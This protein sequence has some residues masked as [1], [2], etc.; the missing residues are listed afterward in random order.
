MQVAGEYLFE[1]YYRKVYKICRKWRYDTRTT[2]SDLT[3][4][5]MEKML[6]L[7]KYSWDPRKETMRDF[8]ARRWY[9]TIGNAWRAE[10]G[11][12]DNHRDPPKRYGVALS[13]DDAL[14]DQGDF[15]VAKPVYSDFEEYEEFE[16]IVSKLPDGLSRLLRD[17][18]YLNLSGKEIA[19]KY[20]L[21]HGS[22]RTLIGEARTRYKEEYEAYHKQK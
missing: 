4:T 5:W 2:P 21:K 14:A 11:I 9:N 8:I 17:R 13:L 18:V 16:I 1:N 19:D 10:H 6:R 22:A 7:I 12:L 20:G 3:Q 15:T